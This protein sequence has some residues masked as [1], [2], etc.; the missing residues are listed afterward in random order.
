M[1]KH[2]LVDNLN[3]AQKLQDFVKEYFGYE[4]EPSIQLGKYLVQ[5]EDSFNGYETSQA[6]Y[7][8]LKI[9]A[10]NKDSEYYKLYGWTNSYGESSIEFSH[11]ATMFKVKPVEKTI[12]DWEDV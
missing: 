5:V 4:S 1:F 9:Q 12:I 8:I 10:N 2:Y 7:I 3:D 6:S 11:W